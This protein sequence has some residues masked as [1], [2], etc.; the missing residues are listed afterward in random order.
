MLMLLEMLGKRSKT[1][2][3][4]EN[5]KDISMNISENPDINH[6]LNN[7]VSNIQAFAE[8]QISQIEHLNEIGAALS[9]EN[10]LDR[11]LEMILEQA[12]N[13]TNADGGT[14]YLMTNDE[15]AL[16]FTVVKTRSLNIAMGG[17]GEA[18]SWPELQLYKDDGSQNREM[19]A[20]LCALEGN[21]INIEDVYEAK[22]FNF[23]GTRAFDKGTGFRSRSMLVIP[24]KNYADEII[25]VCQLINCQHKDTG[26]VIAFDAQAEKSAQSLA[27]QAAIAI[28]NTILI[29]DLK[30]LLESFIKSIAKAIDAKSPYT[31]NHVQK[32]ADISMLIANA[33][34]DCDDGVYRDIH[35]DEDQL[36]EIRIAALMHDVGKITTP[37]Y[38]VDK[39]TKLEAIHD[40]I[41]IV[42]GRFEVY[43]RELEIQALKEKLASTAG[44]AAESELADI[45]N[46][47]AQALQKADD[48]FAFIQASNIG[49]EFMA[50]DKIERI[51]QIASITISM[52]GEDTPL[53]SENEV[54]N[55]SI[56]KGTLTE[57]ERLRINDHARMSNEMLEALPFPKK[58]SRVPEIAGGHHE[59]LN[60]KGY[61]KG[62][63]ADE[64]S[65]EARILAL[66]DIFEALTAADRP[67]KKAKPMDE[68]TRI[69]DFMVK[70][71]ELDPELV[72]FFYEKDLHNTFMRMQKR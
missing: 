50:D 65:L 69:L 18:I 38:V 28:S 17:T 48:D 29:N 44:A 51:Q 67:Y 59:K 6:L 5:E 13:F 27:S 53:L 12:M 70:D 19:V 25:G 9:S 56:R 32:V 58:L 30:L 15:K 3:R 62:L 39:S 42:Q 10:N 60:G 47:L 11:L 14:L 41:A 68:V 37:E 72:G 49:G 24:M 20:A 64:L 55:L 66:A 61:P 46:K 23:E 4:K 57:E 63:S 16:R 31:G 71:Y 2:T 8:K 40:R 1:V 43:K 52:H 22:G 34:N 36:N 26:D 33:L 21:L 35:Y 54:Y 7:V 45:D